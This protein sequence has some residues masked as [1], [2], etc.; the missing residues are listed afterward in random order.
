MGLFCGSQSVDGGFVLQNV[1]VVCRTSQLTVGSF[2]GVVHSV[3]SGFV[4]QKITVSYQWVC[5]AEGHSQLTVGLFCRRHSQL[6]WV[7]FAEG[8]S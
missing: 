3:D 1:T 8:H 7:C 2:C 4:L 5:F 6:K